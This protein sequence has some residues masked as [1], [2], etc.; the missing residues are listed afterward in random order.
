MPSR[1]ARIRYMDEP[2]NSD[3]PCPICGHTMELAGEHKSRGDFGDDAKS[4]GTIRLFRCQKCGASFTREKL[5]RAEAD[6]HSPTNT[7]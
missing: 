7:Y 2:E 5:R 4:Q 6:G 3:P 1:A